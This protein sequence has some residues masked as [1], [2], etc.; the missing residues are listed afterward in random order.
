MVTATRA[1]ELVR[2][3]LRAL[4]AA[5]R[6]LPRNE[7]AEL[8]A[9]IEEHLRDAIPSGAGEAEARTA[10]ERLGDPE[11]IVAEEIERLGIPRPRAGAL[12]WTAIILLLLGGFLAGV[13]WVAGAVML[14]S[15]RAWSMREKLIGTLLVPGGLGAAVFASLLLA[16]DGIQTCGGIAGQPMHC[17][18]G[19]SASHSVLIIAVLI[20]LVLTPIATAVFL[21]RH[22]R[23]PRV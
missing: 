16:S 11:E 4:R 2:A 5:T 12:E 7:R 6:E 10:L 23:A 13:G 22:A 20:L 9:Q 15:S 18:G 8:L 14:W 21:A 17:T 1:D 3:Y 19:W